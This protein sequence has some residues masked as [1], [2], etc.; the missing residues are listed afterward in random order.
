MLICSGRKSARL[1][2]EPN[3][4]HLQGRVAGHLPQYSQYPQWKFEETV[5][6][7]EHLMVTHQLNQTKKESILMLYPFRKS[8]HHLIQ[9]W[10]YL[11]F[12]K[13]EKHFSGSSITT[14]VSV[15]FEKGLSLFQNCFKNEQNNYPMGSVLAIHSGFLKFC[16]SNQQTQLLHKQRFVYIAYLKPQRILSLSLHGQIS[17]HRILI[18]P[19]KDNPKKLETVFTDLVILT[20]KNAKYLMIIF[21]FFELI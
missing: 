16:F 5:T 9:K 19:Q 21:L 2:C 6:S 10:D 1:L 18:L 17:A 20:Q 11:P 15:I 13:F 12:G 7:L 14:E 4:V 3:E 8:V